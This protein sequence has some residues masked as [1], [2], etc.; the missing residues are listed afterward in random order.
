M[1]YV[2]PHTLLDIP[3]DLKNLFR[4]AFFYFELNSLLKIK[5]V[6]MTSVLLLLILI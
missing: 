3:K 5:Q 6:P 1:K 4:F 2:H